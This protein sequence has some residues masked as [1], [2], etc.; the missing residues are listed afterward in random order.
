MTADARKRV[1]I[2]AALVAAVAGGGLI[3]TVARRAGSRGRAG[4]GAAPFV[5]RGGLVSATQ[6]HMGTW[7]T[8]TVAASGDA[9]ASGHLAAAMDRVAGL[10]KVLSAQDKDSELS[11]VNRQ[12]GKGAVAV[13]R[14]LFEAVAAGAAWHARTEGSFDIT[15]SP[16]ISLWQRCGRARRLPTS[17]EI[18]TALALVGAERVRL[19][20]EGRTV[21]LPVAGMRLHLGGLGKGLCADKVAETLRER[22]VRSALIAVSGDIYALGR[23]P[24]GSA[25]RIGVQDPRRPKDAGATV[26]VLHL[27]DRAVST[28]GNYHRFV[29]IGGKRYSHI[30]DPRT[31]RTAGS[32]ASVTVIGPDALTTDILGTALSVLDIVRGLRLVESLAGVEALFITF[33]ESDELVLTR[34]RGF[35]C[36][37]TTAS[38]GG[39]RR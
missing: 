1:W 28:S 31:G 30:V 10:E 2:A 19:N 6:E 16:L 8:I 32:V 14:D 3:V 33:D 25:W 20:R 11:G 35:A 18:Q 17:S 27:A 4:E 5:E 9:A 7:V 12:A 29:E 13:S 34:T 37:E 22:G 36:Y 26:T 38:Q 15:A 24:D 23:R 39:G 21:Q